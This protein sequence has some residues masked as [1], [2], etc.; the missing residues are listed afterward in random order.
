MTYYALWH[1]GHSY[2]HSNDIDDER[3][4][5][6]SIDDLKS[7]L[8]RRFNGRA[9]IRTPGDRYW[10]ETPAVDET[11]YFDVFLHFKPMPDDLAFRVEFG[12]RGGARKV[13]V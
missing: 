9:I 13:N 10:V 5:F 1:G 11:S 4:E 2:R 12:P 8:V 6:D 3:E 7:E